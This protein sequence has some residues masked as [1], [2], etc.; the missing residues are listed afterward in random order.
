MV[1]RDRD[2][3]VSS[4][5]RQARLQ[6][7]TRLERVDVTFL[8]GRIISDTHVFPKHV[9]RNLC[10]YGLASFVSRKVG[11]LAGLPFERSA[12]PHESQNTQR[13]A[14]YIIQS[15]SAFGC[16]LHSE[17]HWSEVSWHRDGQMRLAWP[18]ELVKDMASGTQSHSTRCCLR[19]RHECQ[20]PNLRSLRDPPMHAQTKV[21]PR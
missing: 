13:P 8:L 16:A 20:V 19:V 12:V 15:R 11:S 6:A 18:S 3:R 9:G 10:L 17:K 7:L 4:Y 2:V 14:E 21:R 5:L 1:Q